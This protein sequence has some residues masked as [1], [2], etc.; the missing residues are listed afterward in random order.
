MVNLRYARIFCRWYLGFSMYS[1]RW[2]AEYN[3]LQKFLL[4][5]FKKS[6]VFLRALPSQL[7]KCIWGE[8]AR[9]IFTW[10][11]N[12]SLWLHTQGETRS[13]LLI[14]ARTTPQ[15]K[16]DPIL[17]SWAAVQIIRSLKRKKKILGHFWTKVKILKKLKNYFKDKWELLI[18][19]NPKV[20]KSCWHSTC[21]ACVSILWLMR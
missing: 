1:L 18:K 3:A 19:I 6:S 15:T 12:V 5:L 21:E 10:K 13:S 4:F 8:L 20:N 14:C 16:Q 17:F 9:F 2:S 7:H 11:N